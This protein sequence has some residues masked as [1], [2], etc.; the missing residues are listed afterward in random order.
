MTRPAVG[1]WLHVPEKGCTGGRATET[2]QGRT[3]CIS[4]VHAR[5]ARGGEGES[6]PFKQNVFGGA[7]TRART[8]THN[9]KG[10]ISSTHN[11]KLGGGQFVS[12]RQRRSPRSCVLAGCRAGGAVGSQRQAVLGQRALLVALLVALGQRPED[13][14]ARDDAHAGAVVIHYRH[15]VEL[16]LLGARGRRGSSGRE[17]SRRR[18][19]AGP[20]AGAAAAA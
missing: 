2:E 19:V 6:H 16:V 15:A 20:P 1:H 7:G 4:F 13:V 14:G 12:L 10:G 8:P 17:P 3:G 9:E 5:R 11:E 18:A